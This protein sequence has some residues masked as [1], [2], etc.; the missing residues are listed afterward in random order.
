MNR[1]TIQL[2]AAI[3]LYVAA[4]VSFGTSCWLDVQLWM[5]NGMAL[6]CCGALLHRLAMTAD[7]EHKCRWYRF[8]NTAGMCFMAGAVISIFGGNEWYTTLTIA[9]TYLV[10]TVNLI[11]SIQ[12]KK[13][14]KND[15]NQ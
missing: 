14:E 5:G 2:T 4:I 13:Q 3:M 6:L 8:A 15:K 10:G 9:L 7:E 12:T 11:R 1:R